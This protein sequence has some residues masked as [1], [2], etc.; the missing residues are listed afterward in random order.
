M[1][2]VSNNITHMVHAT[3]NFNFLKSLD[4]ITYKKISNCPDLQNMI[5]KT[6][7]NDE[8]RVN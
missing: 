7:R 2:P 3:Y 1:H 6:K 8:N 5:L 4:F